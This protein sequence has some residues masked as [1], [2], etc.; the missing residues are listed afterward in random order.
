MHVHAEFICLFSL[1]DKKVGSLENSSY[2]LSA[3]LT[4]SHSISRWKLYPAMLTD[5]LHRSFSFSNSAAFQSL[6]FSMRDYVNILPKNI[7]SLRAKHTSAYSDP[8]ENETWTSL[9]RFHSTIRRQ[10]EDSHLS[11]FHCRMAQILTTHGT[12]TQQ[13]WRDFYNERKKDK[14]NLW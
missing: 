9:P 4:Q 5:W 8:T 12:Y 13:Q 2:L 11:L 7:S 6:I 14:L 3:S 1:V 10:S